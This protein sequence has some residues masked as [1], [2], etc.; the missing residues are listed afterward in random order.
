MYINFKITFLTYT[1]KIIK[2]KV[3]TT[4]IVHYSEY[5]V[6]FNSH[7]TCIFFRIFNQ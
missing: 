4:T 1:N 5:A 2:I 6:Y 7:Y 3:C